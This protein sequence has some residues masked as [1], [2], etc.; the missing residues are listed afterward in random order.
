MVFLVSLESSR[1]GGLHGLGSMLQMP[2]LVSLESA[3]RV[4][5]WYHNSW[6]CR[7]KVLNIE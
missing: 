3:Q 4:W 5:A 6:T 2:F 7:A 1:L